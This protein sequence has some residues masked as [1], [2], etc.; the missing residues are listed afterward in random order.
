M[1]ERKENKGENNSDAWNR[2]WTNMTHVTKRVRA[3]KEWKKLARPSIIDWLTW[4]GTG[5]CFSYQ[6][7]FCT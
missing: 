6:Y 3:K 7:N 1:L 4:K 2:S 5:I